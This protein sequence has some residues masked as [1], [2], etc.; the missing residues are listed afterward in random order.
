VDNID[1]RR[2]NMRL[3]VWNVNRA[4]HRKMDALRRLRPD[5]AILAEC[6]GPSVAASRPVYGEAETSAW[7]GDNP[8]QGLAVLGFGDWRV[9]PSDQMG[10]GKLALPVHIEGRLKFGMLALW[11]QQPHYARPAHEAVGAHAPMLSDGPAIVAGDL[12]SNQSFDRARNPGHATLVRAL[13]ERG[14]FSA[15]HHHFGEDQ[16]KETRPTFHMRRQ[17]A[18]YHLDY[19]F[20]PDAWRSRVRS[21]EVGSKAVWAS[22]SDHMPLVVELDDAL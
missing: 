15:Y 1:S 20:L 8:T 14:L 2:E 9:T 13:G 6:A 7:V 4:A 21:V 18:P 17:G 3:V 5:V 12:N 11:T 19:A 16:G 10:G 22:L